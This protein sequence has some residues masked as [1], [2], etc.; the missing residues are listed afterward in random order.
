MN[1]VIAKNEAKLIP[2]H[3]YIIGRVVTINC[4]LYIDTLNDCQPIII[5]R[6][7]N[8]FRSGKGFICHNNEWFKFIGE[9]GKTYNDASIVKHIPGNLVKGY[10]KNNEFIIC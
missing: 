1:L 2:R 4:A 6:S 3:N 5:N 10:I 8:T 7:S 9:K